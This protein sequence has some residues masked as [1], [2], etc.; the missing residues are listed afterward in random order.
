MDMEQKTKIVLAWELHEQGI[1]NT[2][3]AK[4]LE[5]NR[6]TVNRWISAMREQQTG[7]LGYLEGFRTAEKQPRPSRQIPLSTKQLVWQIREREEGCCGQ[8]IAYFLKKE[9]S[10]HLSTP[11]I[12][13]IL[14]QK[15]VLRQKGRK[16]TARGP[17]PEACAPRE[18]V[19]MDT[20]DFGRIFAFTAVDI[21]SREADIL[22]RPSLTARDGLAFLESCMPRRFDNRVQLIQTDGGS[23]FEAE[24]AQAVS[25]YCD[26]HRVSRPYKKNEQSYIESFNRT[27]RSE[28]LGWLKYRPDEIEELTGEVESFLWRY[29][30]H[31]PHLGLD[32]LRSPL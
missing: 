14:K 32:P 29:H 21:F 20:I 18:V 3:I 16:K 6:E 23:E 17:V 7:L 5:V 31:R 30:H 1:S 22:L 9:H 24:F 19:Q 15:F 12:Y 28:C 4:R 13:A 27:V 11:T 25:S 8:K 26:R 2:Q 10:I